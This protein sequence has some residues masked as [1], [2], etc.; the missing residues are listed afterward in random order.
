[1]NSYSR[2]YARVWYETF[3]LVKSDPVEHCRIQR[4][5]ND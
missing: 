5:T 1:M 2:N 3:R 4:E